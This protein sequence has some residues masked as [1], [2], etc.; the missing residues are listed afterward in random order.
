[1]GQT[2]I[3]KLRWPE[4]TGVAADGPDGYQDLATDVENQMIRMRSRSSYSGFFGVPASSGQYVSVPPGQTKPLI[5][6]NIIPPV[7][8][9]VQVEW[10]VTCQWKTGTWH[11]MWLDASLGVPT[12]LQAVRTQ[13]GQNYGFGVNAQWGGRLA[14]STLNRLGQRFTLSC[15]TDAGSDP[16]GN[17]QVTRVG[18]AIQ[19]YGG[20]PV[21]TTNSYQIGHG[22]YNSAGSVVTSF[23]VTPEPATAVGDWMY[24]IYMFRRETASASTFT[25]PS[26][27]V[28]VV[29]TQLSGSA[30]SGL[31][32]AIYRKKRAAGE[33]SYTSTLSSARPVRATIITV[34]QPNDNLPT[35]GALTAT[36]A[37]LNPARITVPGAVA[38]Q[39]GALVLSV[40]LENMVT[41]AQAPI[42]PPATVGAD[43]W[44]T[45]GAPT[46]LD[47][48]FMAVATRSYGVAM[49]NDPVTFTWNTA[50][51]GIIGGVSL[52][53]PPA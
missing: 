42:Q 34:R 18:Y 37:G 20:N 36:R 6:M 12:F 53:F 27:F 44:Y 40:A 24:L 3:Y 46:Y 50:D 38:V 48:L 14:N 26:G 15:R 35:V 28:A 41:A 32:W 47:T 4:R 52:I 33:T 7:A 45:V 13:R 11:G 17:F 9:W 21:A 39:P 31:Q 29:S 1:M 16:A 19:H 23:A 22:D 8:G 2:D 30:T 43:N 25:P 5:D 49:S 51:A 10:F